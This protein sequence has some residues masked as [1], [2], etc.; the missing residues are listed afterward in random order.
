M[1]A[2]LGMDTPDLGKR[3][4]SWVQVTEVQLYQLEDIFFQPGVA[5]FRY[6]LS[7]YEIYNEKIIDL[8]ASAGPDSRPSTPLDSS[9]QKPKPAVHFHPRYGAFVSNLN[10]L[11][12]E[13][14]D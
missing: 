1:F 13:N 6:I 11:Q 4:L 2:S 8:L 5:D 12:V 9:R 14:F 10:E 7:F 3:T